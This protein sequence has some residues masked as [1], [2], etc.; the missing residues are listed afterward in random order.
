MTQSKWRQFFAVALVTALLVTSLAPAAFAAE[1][2]APSYEVR[3]SEVTGMIPGGQ[4]AKIWLGIVPENPGT[5]NV[6]ATWDRANPEQNGVGFFILNEA[7]LAAVVAGQNLRDNNVASGSTNFFLN[8]PDNQQGASFRATGG[9]YTAIVYNDSANDA[10]FTM[11]VDNGVLVDESDQVKAPGAAAEEAMTETAEAETAAETTPAAAPA[12]ATPEATVEATAVA[13]DVTTSTTTT[14]VASGPFRG[15][16]VEGELPEQYAQH[17]LGLE[18]TQR[19]ADITLRM[20]FDPRD[21]QEL[22]RRLGFWVLDDQGFRRYQAGENAGDVAVAAGNRVSTPG[23]D[24]VRSAS[25]NASG[26]GSY[27]VIVYNNSRIPATYGL[28]V[29]G[30]VLIDDAQQ[31]ITAQQNVTGTVA[32]AAT[33]DE[34]VAA[35]TTTTATTTAGAGREGEPGG[36]YTV[37]S[38][39]TLALIARDIYGDFRL[40]EQLCAFNSIADCNIIEVGQVIKLPT[41]AEIGASATTTTAAA[42]PAAT[43][44]AEPVATTAAT[45]ATTTAT[46]TETATVTTTTPVT[47]TSTTTSTTGTRPSTGSTAAGTIAE[48]AA[49]NPNFSILSKALKATGLDATLSSGEYTVFAP[50]DAAF[51]VLLDTTGLTADQLLQASELSQILQYHVLSGAVMAEDVTNGMKATTV[52]G[53]P[54]TFEIKDGSVYINGA[55][56]TITDI[57]ASNGVI[58]AISAVILPPAQ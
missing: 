45:T 8:G 32:V 11:S 14:V 41:N 25:F 12:E 58:H 10:N 35:T 22:A 6:T 9:G 16:A 51:N 54:V 28:A 42:T 1:Q 31:T 38:G 26:F 3:A 17:Y 30:G 13:T 2:S 19:D 52:Q 56:V 29:E 55:K 20:T 43:T 49:S 44:A 48:V 33:G 36:T 46:T 53:K 37:Q 23:E 21:N 27:T 47:S 5:V 40:Y 50:T 57:P 7:N 18:P 15:A 34:T 24:N 4:F 39:D